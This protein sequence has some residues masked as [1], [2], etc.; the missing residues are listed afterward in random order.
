[1]KNLKIEE[2]TVEFQKQQCYLDV[3]QTIPPEDLE[4]LFDKIGISAIG[5]R[6]KI[7]RAL[8]DLAGEKDS[9]ECCVNVFD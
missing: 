6:L 5:N 9:L 2:L 4:K 7:K 3:L 8:Q 1:M